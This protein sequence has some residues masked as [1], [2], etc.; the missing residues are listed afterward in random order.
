MVKKLLTWAAIGF[1]V[2]Y[3]VTSPS[4]AADVIHST[5]RGLDRL[6]KGFSNFITSL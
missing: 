2:F 1:V 6:A 4:G 5:V 3:V